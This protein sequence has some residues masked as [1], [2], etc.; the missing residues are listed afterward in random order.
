MFLWHYLAMTKKYIDFHSHTFYS[1]GLEEPETIVRNAKMNGLDALALTDHD[2]TEGVRDAQ[3]EARKWNIQLIPGVEIT[4]NNYHT[5]GLNVDVGSRELQELLSCSRDLQRRTCERRIN[6]MQRLG[7][8][9]TFAKV[10]KLF[11]KSRL[12]KYNL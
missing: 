7:V 9:I 6:L 8:P 11:P 4:T 12:G 10:E 5:L 2:T 3:R 1:D